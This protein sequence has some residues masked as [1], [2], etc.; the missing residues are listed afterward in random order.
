[1]RKGRGVRVRFGGLE[2]SL[3]VKD[4]NE[5]MSNEMYIKIGDFDVI[6]R[7]WFVSFG[8]TFF[9]TKFTRKT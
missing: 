8:C 6:G 7:I 9:C 1:M 3:G 5:K 4:G 2:G